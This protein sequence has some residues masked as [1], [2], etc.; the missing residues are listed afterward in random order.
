MLINNCAIDITATSILKDRQPKQLAGRNALA[1]MLARGTSGA[2]PGRSPAANTIL[3]GASLETGRMVGVEEP[4]I[5]LPNIAPYITFNPQIALF[6]SQPASKRWVLQAIAQSIREVSRAEAVSRGYLIYKYSYRFFPKIVDPVVE[7]SVAIATV[8]TRELVAKDFAV[9]ADENKM[10]K[11]AHLM[12][13]NLAG[14]LAMVTCKEPL[15]Q[16]M[17]QNLRNIFLMNGLNDVSVA[18]MLISPVF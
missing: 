5:A 15:R 18:Y 12:A 2:M 4:A 1:E 14:S 3:P 8:S 17:T 13:Q 11:A 16:S 10:R 7:R 9:E 6:S